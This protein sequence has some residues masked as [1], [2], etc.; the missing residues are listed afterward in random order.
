MTYKREIAATITAK[1]AIYLVG[2]A[3]IAISVVYAQ[4]PSPSA[5]GDSIPVT[6]DNFVRAETDMYFRQFAKNGGFGKFNHAR[7][8]PLGEDTGVRPNRDTLYSLAVFDLDAGPVTIALPDAGQRFMTMMVVDE[9]H[10]VCLVT[11]GK[12]T[13]TLDRKTIG[14]RYVFAAVRTLVDLADPQDLK[15]AHALQDAVKVSQ[16]SV[17]KLETPNWDSVSQKKVRDALLVLNETLPDLKRAG[18]RREEVDPV[19][20]LIAT[21][22]AWGLNPDKDAIYLNVTPARNDGTTVYRL[23]VKDVPVDGF[24]SVIVY[25][26][27][28]L[29]LKNSLDAYSLNNTTAK[30]GADGSVAIQ[31]GGC[32]G[33]IP[34]CLPIMK[35]WNYMVRLYRPRK[36]ILDGTWKF[37]EA[38]PQ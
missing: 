10:Y 28:G 35:G 26:Q 12:G 6:P 19:R 34:N 3:F 32:D 36:D 11:Y 2:I 8:L 21:A 38:Q 24:W 16:R 22:S 29:I 30:K 27:R 23:N 37:P 25:D 15:Q 4:S 7:D 17:G 18:G 14:T 33:K 31:F 1:L 5:T 20:H 9:D 13:H